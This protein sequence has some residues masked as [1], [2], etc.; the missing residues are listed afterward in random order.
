[1]HLLHVFSRYIALVGSNVTSD[2]SLLPYTNM[3]TFTKNNRYTELH[4]ILNNIQ[5]QL[6]WISALVNFSSAYWFHTDPGRGFILIFFHFLFGKIFVI[7]NFTFFSQK[8]TSRGEIKK[9]SLC[10]TPKRTNCNQ[11]NTNDSV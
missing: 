7:I 3:A 10:F 9:M 5:R 6:S 8:L 11:I 4:A 2:V 1:M